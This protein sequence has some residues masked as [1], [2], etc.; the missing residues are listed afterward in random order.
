MTA[1]TRRLTTVTGSKGSRKG[2][3]GCSA[4]E[5]MRGGGSKG[6]VKRASSGRGGSEAARAGRSWKE[7]GEDSLPPDERRPATGRGAVPVTV[8]T[9]L[10]EVVPPAED[11]VA[12]TS[13]M[14][15][16]GETGK[17]DACGRESRTKGP[18]LVGVGEQAEA[19]VEGAALD[20]SDPGADIG[21][22]TGAETGAEMGAEMGVDTIGGLVLK[23]M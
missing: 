16:I 3:G 20:A 9:P 11:G 8:T 14:V 10:P 7:A 12:D 17:E 6:E 21:A 13:T 22:E 2:C 19:G 18:G 15:F 5:A 23:Q 4:R 1:G